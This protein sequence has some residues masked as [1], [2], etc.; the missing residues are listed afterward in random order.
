[1]VKTQQTAQ[2]SPTSLEILSKQT[3]AQERWL[4]I[5]D[6]LLDSK[7]RT[8]EVATPIPTQRMYLIQIR[9]RIMGK[10]TIVQ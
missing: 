10:K 7:S 3:E 6:G 1:L 5:S 9:T 2:T 4:I 8:V